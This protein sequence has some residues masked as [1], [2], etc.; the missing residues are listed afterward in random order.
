[1]AKERLFD[2]DVYTGDDSGR[3]VCG[4]TATE[5]LAVERVQAA[6][7]ELPR[8]TSAWAE[9]TR[10]RLDPSHLAP[11]ERLAHGRLVAVRLWDGTVLWSRPHLGQG[12]VDMPQARQA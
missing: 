6:F 7:A 9:V 8:G 4:V 5:K 10:V 12:A 2:W 3:S 11:R 1:M